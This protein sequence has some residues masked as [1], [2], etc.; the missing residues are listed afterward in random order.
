MILLPF[1]LF[2]MFMIGFKV[3]QRSRRLV[4]LE[5]PRPPALDAKN[6]LR[7][8]GFRIYE[9]D[10][11]ARLHM[12]GWLQL[13]KQSVIDGHKCLFCGKT[14][15]RL[16]EVV[17]IGKAEMARLNEVGFYCPNPR[18][19][20]FHRSERADETG[21]FGSKLADGTNFFDLLD[22][23]ELESG[24]PLHYELAEKLA[25]DERLFE[26]RARDVRIRRAQLTAKMAG[27]ALGPY[28]GD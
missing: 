22:R 9:R 7:L 24:R 3:G 28:R 6:R 23:M 15:V 14:T 20:Y 19:G 11:S 12:T 4:E 1:L 17:R 2:G 16:T 13:K 10:T 27:K 18:C 25:N 26:D 21:F 5:E 8:L